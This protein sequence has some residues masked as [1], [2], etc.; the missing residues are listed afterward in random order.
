VK[1]KR[2]SGRKPN[3]VGHRIFAGSFQSRGAAETP[4]KN[5][6]TSNHP[7]LTTFPRRSHVQFDFNEDFT[8]WPLGP[9]ILDLHS[10]QSLVL[11]RGRA[12]PQTEEQ[13]PRYPCAHAFRSLA[14]RISSPGFSS[15]SA[16]QLS[17][18]QADRRPV[19]TAY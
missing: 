2:C 9:T 17:S 19:P 1:E 18:C 13:S 7:G 4:Q 11:I 8:Q 3:G 16:I 14:N 10:M 12:T 6:P 15:D 5:P